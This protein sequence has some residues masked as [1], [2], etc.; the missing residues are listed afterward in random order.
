MTSMDAGTDTQMDEE[1]PDLNEAVNRSVEISTNIDLDIPREKF[2]ETMPIPTT[3]K[4]RD[5][6]TQVED[7]EEIKE[8]QVLPV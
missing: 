4:I 1:S 5:M 2:S 8:E 7:E 3:V 6:G